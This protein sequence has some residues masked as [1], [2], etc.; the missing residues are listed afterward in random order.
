[1]HAL[2]KRLDPVA[3]PFL[4]GLHF[5]LLQTSYFLL[6]EAHLSSQSLSYF[7]TLFF[8]LLGLLVGLNLGADRWFSGLLGAG[9]LGYY[10]TFAL[11]RALPFHGALYPVAAASSVISGLLPG[12]FFRFAARRWAEVRGPL[13]HENNGFLLGLVLALRGA[14]HF[15]GHLLAFGPLLGAALV[16]AAKAAEGRGEERHARS[17]G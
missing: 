13:F 10:V 3:L 17:A 6:L 8:W 1:M 7:V 2:Q 15:G 9:V 16:L 11:A 5:A 14:I 4:A 12:F